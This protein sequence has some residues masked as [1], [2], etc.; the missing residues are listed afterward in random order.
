LPVPDT[1]A[2]AKAREMIHDVLK[3]EYAKTSAADRQALAK[4]LL[5]EASAIKNDA[6]A[7]YVLLTEAVDFAAGVGD[8]GIIVQAIQN[9]SGFY[10]VDA[11]ELTRA[12]LVRAAAVELSSEAAEALS[13]ACLDTA[14]AASVTDGFETV[15]QL[16]NLAEATATRSRKVAYVASIQMRLADL[17]ALAAE[18]TQVSQ[19]LAVLEKHPDNA[20]AHQTIGR[21]Y[22]LHKGQWSQG[23][24]HLAAGTDE[25]MRRIAA[26]E[27]ENPGDPIDQLAIGD[28]WW[29]LAQKSTGVA[30]MQMTRHAQMW[31]RHCRASFTDIALSRIQMRLQE[32]M[33]A[34]ATAP[35]VATA[36]TGTTAAKAVN[37]LAL[38]DPA[39]DK[40]EGEWSLVGNNLVVAPGRYSVLSLP[41][42]MPAEYEL[43]VSFTRVEGTGAICVLLASH[44]KSFGFQLDV[45]SEA[46]FER[47]ASKV[48]KENPTSV[49]VAISNGKRYT[50]C[51]QIRNDSVQALLDDKLITQWKTDYKDLSRYPMWKISND[52]LCGLGA[53]HA[54]VVFHTVE[55]VEISGTGKPVR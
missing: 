53:N 37:L 35:S 34:P 27:L 25:T 12:A 47:V 19:A 18:F 45:K 13:L 7:R 50:L 31:Y 41:Y 28:A 30:H 21:F 5:S 26:K 3:S 38:I 2:C 22:A 4:R 43:R 36:A 52:K 51:M 55:L 40:S 24:R 10:A 14:E 20:G 32:E 39:K 42:H 29:E 1:A 33:S 23:L 44:D 48:A 9:L 8:A 15:A 16:A 49:P 6:V 54:K 46:R 11:V 17:R